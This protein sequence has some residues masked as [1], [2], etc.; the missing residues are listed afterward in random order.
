MLETV[1]Q[2]TRFVG[3]LLESLGAKLQ[4]VLNYI[5]AL[6]NW[7]DILATEQV[8]EHALIELKRVA[9]EAVASLAEGAYVDQG[10]TRLRS[11]IDTNFDSWVAALGG[12]GGG[13]TATANPPPQDVQSKYVQALFSDN[14]QHAGSGLDAFQRGPALL[15]VVEELATRLQTAGGNLWAAETFQNSGLMALLQHPE[16]LLSG[17]GLAALLGVIRPLLD[18]ALEVAG[19]VIHAVLELIGIVLN[20][21]LA[22]FTTR[23]NIPFLTD[24]CE[25]VVFQG[26]SQLT[27]LSLVSLLAAIPFTIVYKLATGHTQPPLHDS[28]IQMLRDLHWSGLWSQAT[29]ALN[30]GSRAL[31]GGRPRPGP[32]RRRGLERG[33]LGAKLRQ[34][35][36]ERGAGGDDPDRRR[37]PGYCRAN[38]VRHRQGGTARD[39]LRHRPAARCGARRLHRHPR[40]AELR[41]LAVGAAQPGQCVV[42][43]RV[44]PWADYGDPGLGTFFGV[45]GVAIFTA[46]WVLKDQG[47]EA[48][49]KNDALEGPPISSPRW[50]GWTQFLKYTKN[51]EAVVVG[52]PI[53]L[54]VDAFT[55]TAVTA[56]NIGRTAD[57]IRAKA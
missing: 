27:I 43:T 29:T 14:I 42:G 31:A 4:D 32:A 40:R 20:A 57:D 39:R 47:A 55:Y 26:Q 33:G 53:L 25:Q 49:T 7:S 30:G 54:A 46:I 10:I 36:A 12:Q 2:A 38:A 52:F 18:A 15:G 35:R 5:K 56:F 11:L 22:L 37:D 17:Q 34:R 16:N 19:A 51:T 13:G 28:D 44:E 3:T 9:A 48:D 6:F 41:L 23:I 45:A 24:F 8:I 21:I 50:A 1:E